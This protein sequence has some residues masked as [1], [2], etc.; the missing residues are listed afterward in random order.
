MKSV[1]RKYGLS[2]AELA[3]ANNLGINSKLKKGRRLTI[4]DGG[5]AVASRKAC[6]ATTKT[7]DATPS[8]TY[9]ARRGDSLA[10]IAAKNGMTAAELASINGLSPKSKLKRGQRI[11]LVSS[12]EK[13][14]AAAAAP[15]DDSSKP[16][17]S[18]K[19]KKKTRVAVASKKTYPS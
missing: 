10:S 19:S 5:V 6:P 16:E 8:K 14:A 17:A 7:A 2:V 18:S 1:A 12:G 11:S 3:S 9:R 4:P 13:V 15:D